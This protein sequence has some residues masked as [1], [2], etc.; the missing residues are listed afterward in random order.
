MIFWCIAY[1][2]SSFLDSLSSTWFPQRIGNSTLSLIWLETWLEP[3]HCFQGLSLSLTCFLSTSED[4]TVNRPLHKV[5]L[6][7]T[8]LYESPWARSSCFCPSMFASFI[9]QISTF[10]LLPFYVCQF[11]RSKINNR[12]NQYLLNISPQNTSSGRC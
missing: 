11:Y 7:S 1:F 12:L 10:L 3:E 6:L 2:L 8:Y 9:D 5:T 4:H